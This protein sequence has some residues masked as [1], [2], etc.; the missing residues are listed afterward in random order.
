MHQHTL[1]ENKLELYKLVN[2]YMTV[3]SKTFY[4]IFSEVVN[5]K[6]FFVNEKFNL[7]KLSGWV[8]NLNN[9]YSLRYLEMNKN[10]IEL[11]PHSQG[12]K[13]IVISVSGIFHQF[14]CREKVFCVPSSSLESAPPVFKSSSVQVFNL[15]V[16]Y[17]IAC[18]SKAAE[19]SS[20]SLDRSE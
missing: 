11:G 6:D 8:H 13:N 4:Q 9:N 20:L 3:V 19:L 18:A 10:S 16:Q 2:I 12:H 5:R 17:S 15:N 7:L 14:Y 1:E